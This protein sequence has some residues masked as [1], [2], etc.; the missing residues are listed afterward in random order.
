[1]SLAIALR[2][3]TGLVLAADSR[4]TGPA[5]ISED[6]SE[7][8]LQIN[9][10]TGVLTF[11]LKDPGYSG[12]T[13]LVEATK[14]RRFESFA[15]ITTEAQ[16]I[17]RTEY[18]NW[19]AVADLPPGQVMG[20]GAV[21]FVVGG[22]DA[23]HSNQFKITAYQS[24]DFAPNPMELPAFLAARWHIAQAVVDFFFYPEMTVDQL[25]RLAVLALM[26]TMTRDPT[27]GGPIQLATVTWGQGFRK[28]TEEEILRYIHANQATIVGFS[29]RL[30]ELLI[31]G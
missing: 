18:Q 12:I 17:F 31:G 9:R 16:A 20:P 4:A 22:Y 25:A 7:K 23:V 24:P 10:D 27:V 15:R 21:A 1:M 30:N 13:K 14:A 8:F 6:T 2:G 29:K 26:E 5:G 19:L 11:G 28:V 3:Y